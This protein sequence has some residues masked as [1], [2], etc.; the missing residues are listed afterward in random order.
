MM[1]DLSLYLKSEQWAN[2]GIEDAVE[3]AAG[4]LVIFLG[5]K[6]ITDLEEIAGHVR[7]VKEGYTLPN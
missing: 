4:F 3:K 7:K 6:E 5:Y 1:K 2:G